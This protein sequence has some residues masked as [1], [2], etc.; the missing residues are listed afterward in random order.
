MWTASSCMLPCQDDTVD[1]S[2]HTL[3]AHKGLQTAA[4]WL[5][6]VQASCLYKKLGR[7]NSQ[8][9]NYQ[10]SSSHLSIRSLKQLSFQLTTQKGAPIWFGTE[11]LQ[12]DWSMNCPSKTTGLNLSSSPCIHLPCWLPPKLQNTHLEAEWAYF[13]PSPTGPG[14]GAMGQ[15]YHQV[16]ACWAPAALHRKSKPQSVPN[17]LGVE[18]GTGIFPLHPRNSI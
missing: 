17:T 2:F 18:E 13:T 5:L 15:Q 10:Q 3:T 7:P 4:V 1:H 11:L 9:R 12:T 8:S 16:L 14:R 6:L